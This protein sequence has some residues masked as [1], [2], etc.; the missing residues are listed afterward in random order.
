MQWRTSL[1]ILIIYSIQLRAQNASSRFNVISFYN[2][3]EDQA[4]NSFDR[5][6]NVWFTEMSEKYQ[7]NYES[8]DN[9]DN[10]NLQLLSNYQVV[11]FLDGRPDSINQRAAFRQYMESGGSW[12]GF[13][14]S[15]FALTPSAFPQNWEWYHNEFLGVGEYKGNTWRPTSAILK[16]ENPSHPATHNL[17]EIFTSAPNEWYSWEKDLRSDAD[18]DILISIDPQSFPLGTGPKP[19]EIWYHG[20]YPVVWTNR[21]YHMIYMNMGHND[22]DYENETIRELSQTFSSHEQNKLIINALLWLASQNPAK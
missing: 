7:F 13:H 3:K 2:A 20:D 1:V 9:W 8:T 18:I 10:L 17:P 22:I 5:E 19:H 21:K 12:M 15:G 14:F 11:I 6:A 4:H 16:V